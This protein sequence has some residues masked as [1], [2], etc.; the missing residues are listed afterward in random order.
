MFELP[1][2]KIFT[3]INVNALTR[4]KEELRNFAH[5]HVCVYITFKAMKHVYNFPRTHIVIF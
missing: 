5:T 2:V 3:F 4:I 1:N